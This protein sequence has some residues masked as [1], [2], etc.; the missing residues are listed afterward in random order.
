M[1]GATLVLSRS[2]GV[3]ISSDINFKVGTST[4]GWG[5]QHLR[6][7]NSNLDVTNSATFHGG[8]RRRDEHQCQ[9]IRK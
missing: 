5:Q 4:H 6:R 8:R 7:A 3:T 1:N 9:W 2:D